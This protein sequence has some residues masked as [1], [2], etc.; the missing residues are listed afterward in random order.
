MLIMMNREHNSSYEEYT[1]F[2]NWYN[3]EEFT[4]KLKK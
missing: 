4:E 1:K 3:F 2:K